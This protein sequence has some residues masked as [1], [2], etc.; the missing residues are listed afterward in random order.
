MRKI[1]FQQSFVCESIMKVYSEGSSWQQRS[2][3]V[4]KGD[5]RGGQECVCVRVSMWRPYVGQWSMSDVFFFSLFTYL[6]F[7][8][9]ELGPIHL[10]RQAGHKPQESSFAYHPSARIAKECKQV[11]FFSWVLGMWTQVLM[12]PRHGKMPDLSSPW[13]KSST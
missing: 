4:H 12:L 5:W 3:S 10:N 7:F 11:W 1:V 2:L 13:L 6:F 9:F 8:F